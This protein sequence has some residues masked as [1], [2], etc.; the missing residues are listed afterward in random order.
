M[1]TI[2]LAYTIKLDRGNDPTRDIMPIYFCSIAE[3]CVTLVSL[4]V[5]S[6][7]LA[8]RRKWTSPAQ[9]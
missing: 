7:R 1:A 6:L 8:V 4:S 2:R 9:C 5:A 3:I